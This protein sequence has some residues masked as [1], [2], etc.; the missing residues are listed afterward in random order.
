MCGGNERP[1]QIT[2]AAPDPI[3]LADAHGERRVDVSRS[4][5]ELP[6]DPLVSALLRHGRFFPRFSLCSDEHDRAERGARPI[7]T[8]TAS[9]VAFVSSRH[10]LHRRWWLEP[11]K[12]RG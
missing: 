9:P 12:L 5:L 8:R 11:G 2:A 3:L 7:G 1:I 6:P 10:H 4:L